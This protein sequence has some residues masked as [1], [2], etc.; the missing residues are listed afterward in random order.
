MFEGFLDTIQQRIASA[1]SGVVSGVADYFY[2]S[3]WFAI[4][5]AIILACFVIGFFFSHPWVRAFLGFV[6]WGGVAFLVGMTIMFKH[7]RGRPKVPPPK[8]PPV[9]RP[10]DDWWKFP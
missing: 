9:E 1:F 6:V 2:I 5:L 3:E 7:M 10:R 4:V 8:P